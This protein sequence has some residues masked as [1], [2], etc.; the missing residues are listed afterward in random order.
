M[1]ATPKKLGRPPTVEGP[2][3]A[4]RLP[5]ALRAA[6]EKWAAQQPD[7]PGRS[8]AIRRLIEFGLDAAPR[9]V[10]VAIRT[11]H[12]PPQFVNLK[13]TKERGPKRKK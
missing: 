3:T 8:E 5:P 1:A 4:I 10:A 6:V 2:V 12:G 11:E 13:T 7:K 9:M